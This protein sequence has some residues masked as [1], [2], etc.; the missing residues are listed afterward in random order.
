MNKLVIAGFSIHATL[1]LPGCRE[2]CL[3]DEVRQGDD[4]VMVSDRA[5][6]GSAD[7]SF[8]GDIDAS[9]DG[10]S[11]AE[12]GGTIAAD[13]PDDARVDAFMDAGDPKGCTGQACDPCEPN[14]CR[15][16]GTCT[17]EHER[18][19]C[20]CGSGYEG[21]TCETDIDECSTEDRCMSVDYPCVQTEAWVRVPGPVRGLAD[22]RF[23]QRTE[24]VRC[25]RRGRRRSGDRFDVAA[26]YTWRA[27]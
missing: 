24:R 10:E 22:A 23:P 2:E 1:V 9:D 8:E 11:D 18:A 5:L 25:A 12:E 26:V 7:A 3:L 6:E 20:T 16:D 17:I 27:E 4:C 21:V 19:R 13:V 14:P 15:H